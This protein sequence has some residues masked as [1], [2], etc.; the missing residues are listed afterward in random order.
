MDTLVRAIKITLDK[1]SDTYS[2]DDVK[3]MLEKY[4]YQEDGSKFFTRENGARDMVGSLDRT[5]L[6]EYFK[7]N[8]N[9]NGF[10]A[11]VDEFINKNFL[12]N[13]DSVLI[14]EKSQNIIENIVPANTKTLSPSEI[15]ECQKDMNT[16]AK[17]IAETLKRYPDKNNYDD[18]G[19][20]IYGYLIYGNMLSFTKSN[21]MRDLASTIDR[22]RLY[23]YFKNYLNPDGYN[24]AVDEFIYINLNIGKSEIDSGY[25]GFIKELDKKTLLQILPY[26]YEHG[27]DSIPDLAYTDF[28]VEQ[29]V[30]KYIKIDNILKMQKRLEIWSKTEIKNLIREYFA[31]VDTSSYIQKKIETLGNVCIFEDEE[32]Y[33]KHAPQDS[34]GCNNGINSYIMVNEYSTFEYLSGVSIHE[35]LHQLSHIKVN[36]FFEKNGVEEYKRKIKYRGINESIT[37]LFAIEIMKEK[38]YA[39]KSCGYYEPVQY[40]RAILQMNIPGLNIETLKKA[41][42]NNDISLIKNAIDKV[43]GARFF[44]KKLVPAFDHAIKYQIAELDKVLI[45]MKIKMLKKK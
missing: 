1:H 23:E 39:P 16:L 45:E 38:G 36:S 30:R 43:M 11:A 10:D 19:S 34:D 31:S 12:K 5:R 35:S 33:R 2:Y 24:A 3:E 17:V 40:L 8:L 15:V 26:A 29:L 27:F 44:E 20:I 14:E 21:G 22:T 25:F 13:Q 6:Y 9:P 32:T 41:Y 4:F 42:I 37:E 28:E 7:N 18:I